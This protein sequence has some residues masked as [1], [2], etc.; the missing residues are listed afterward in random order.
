M[1]PAFPEQ[2][3]T[4]CQQEMRSGTSQGADSVVHGE[5]LDFIQRALRSHGRVL[6]WEV[7]VCN[8][9]SE[10]PKENMDYCSS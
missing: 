3:V 9:V 2:S 4:E 10:K 1:R 6:S 5:Q 7:T 8:L